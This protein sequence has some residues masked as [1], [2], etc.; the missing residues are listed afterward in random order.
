MHGLLRIGQVSKLYGISL[1][2]LRH[3]DRKGLLEPIVDSQSGYRYYSLEHLDILEMI[4]VGKFTEI[5]LDQMKEKI[6]SESINGYLSMIQEQRSRI[7]EKQKIL[8]QLGQYTE[9]MLELLKTITEF[10]NDYSFSSA[11]INKEINLT[12]Y[13]V[14]LQT[15]LGENTIPHQIDGMESFEQWFSYQVKA[16]G[17][18][19][20]NG[21]TIGLSV[22]DNMIN[23]KI[24]QRS[25]EFASKSDFVSRHHI[26]GCYG[27]ISFWGTQKDLVEYLYELCR[28]FDLHD[29]VLLIKFRFA[30]PHKSMDHEYF[31]DIY[32]PHIPV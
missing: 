1:D 4:L 18:I 26:A 22:L 21:E 11:T 25:L 28:H 17:T 29:T 7:Y 30:L 24:L 23:T 19:V 13:N 27:I 10:K 6:D 20:E 16:N 14:D 5:P 15:L 9:G 8:N 2:T 31:V 32:F 3:Y 12:I